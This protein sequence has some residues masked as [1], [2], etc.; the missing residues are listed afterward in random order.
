LTFHPNTG[1][2][3]SILPSI[4]TCDRGRALSWLRNE[5]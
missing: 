5:N 3:T 1:W 4:T 2:T